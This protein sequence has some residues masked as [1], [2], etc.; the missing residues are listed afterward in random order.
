V[1]PPSVEIRADKRERVLP[2][3]RLGRP[4]ESDSAGRLGCWS[5]RDR[6]RRSKID[7]VLVQN[8]SKNRLWVAL[9]T[10]RHRMNYG[11]GASCG[12]LST[13]RGGS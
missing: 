7:G 9:A 13:A 11:I 10:V 4:N 5:D 1:F 12:V 2:D 3:E 8:Q 6:S